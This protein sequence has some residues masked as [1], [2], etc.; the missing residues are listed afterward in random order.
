MPCS[1]S[2]C[3]GIRRCTDAIF[4]S[5]NDIPRLAYTRLREIFNGHEQRDSCNKNDKTPMLMPSNPVI[6]ALTFYGES[7]IK[8]PVDDPEIV[9]FLKATS[10]PGPFHDEVPWCSAF[11]V[12]IFKQCRIQNNANAAALSWMQFG[13]HSDQPVLG[14]VVVLG[15]PKEGPT[16]HHVGL[17]IREVLD[18]VYVLA[19]NQ[20]NTVDIA[21]WKKADV[22][23]YRR[24]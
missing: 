6:L 12:W 9:Q 1:R 3:R 24:Y 15:W 2:F 14:D 11:L 23:S 20:N 8:G 16:H 18:G 21:L 5:F 10:F 13:V 7:P 17:F 22:L 4:N 19:G